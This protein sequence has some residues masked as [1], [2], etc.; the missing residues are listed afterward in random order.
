MG[1]GRYLRVRVAA[2]ACAGDRGLSGQILLRGRLQPAS[3]HHLGAQPKR[4]SAAH[5]QVRA[6][7]ALGRPD[8]ARRLEASRCLFN[9]V[10]ITALPNGVLQIHNV[11]PEDSG[12]YRCVAT[13]AASRLK[14]EEAA[15]TVKR[16]TGPDRFSRRR[17][18]TQLYLLR[19]AFS[20]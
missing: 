17:K 15:L 3:R 8:G 11:R 10:R 13:N 6:Q 19:V 14:S 20:R 7:A 5:R 1:F 16:G 4:A 12:R 18:P 9:V 2:C